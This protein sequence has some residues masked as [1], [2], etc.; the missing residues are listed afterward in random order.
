MAVMN[1]FTNKVWMEKMFDNFLTDNFHIINP[2]FSGS[3]VG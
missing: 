1:F 3:Y 2:D